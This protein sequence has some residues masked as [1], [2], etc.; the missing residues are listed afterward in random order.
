MSRYD[1][2]H[3]GGHPTTSP[4]SAINPRD[5][6]CGVEVDGAACGRWRV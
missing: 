1:F 5:N 2:E 6:A 3:W 4:M